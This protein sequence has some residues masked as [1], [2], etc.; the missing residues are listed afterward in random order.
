MAES[1][2]VDTGEPKTSPLAYQFWAARG[3][4]IDT[5]SNVEHVFCE[6]FAHLTKME[7]G[8][9]GLIFFRVNNTKVLGEILMTL[10]EKTYAKS[11]NTFFRSLCGRAGEL[12]NVRNGI[13]HRSEAS[14]AY[15][16]GTS[17]FMLIKPDY[18]NYVPE[19]AGEIYLKDVLAF[20]DKCNFIWTLCGEFLFFLQAD[21]SER[22]YEEKRRT[23]QQIF[24]RN[25]TYPPQSTHPL[26][27]RW[28][29]QQSQPPP[30]PS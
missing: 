25:V 28:K 17:G 20:I 7:I 29:A 3:Q 15:T 2:N 1:E 8:I 22:W 26:Y 24:E 23:W 18:W 27:Q 4:A 16:D 14:F 9:A 10:M 5:Y 21:P 12:A 19:E 6:L 11:Y 30:F 13:V